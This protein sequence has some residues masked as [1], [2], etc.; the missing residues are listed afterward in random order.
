MR[1]KSFFRDFS[2]FHQICQH[3]HR[4]DADQ[5]FI[6]YHIVQP[7]AKISCILRT[8]EKDYLFFLFQPH[9]AQNL[10]SQDTQQL[11]ERGVDALLR[12]IARNSPP[13]HELVPFQLIEGESVAQLS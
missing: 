11:A 1:D 3:P 4:P 5:L 12:G 13:V 6:L 2:S 9:S 8:V 7:E 10:V